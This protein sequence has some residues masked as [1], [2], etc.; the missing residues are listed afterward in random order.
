MK[1]VNVG[2]DFDI[3]V[4][5]GTFKGSNAMISDER[6][7][8]HTNADII[9][10]FLGPTGTAADGILYPERTLFDFLGLTASGAFY[11]HK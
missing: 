10:A 5:D 8:I 11:V 1:V 6:S 7:N 4:K 3:N 9:G 2:D